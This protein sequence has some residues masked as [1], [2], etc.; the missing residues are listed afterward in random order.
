MSALAIAFAAA[1]PGSA[2]ALLVATKNVESLKD[3]L[4]LDVRPADAYAA[5][6][7]PGALNLDVSSLSE[8]RDNISGLLKPID[9]VRTSLGNA[10]VDP[11]KRIVVYSAMDKAS[12]ISAAAR[13]FWILEYIGYEKVAVLDGGFTK[14]LAEK[15]STE[16]GAST[17]KPVAVL[18]L[19]VREDRL[20]TME[21]VGL[22]IKDK[23]ATLVDARGPDYFSGE[24]KAD[25]VKKAGHLPGAVNLPV[26]TCVSETSDLK[27]WD[28]L[29]Q[30]AASSNVHKVEPVIT[31]CNTGRSA[32]AAYLVLRLLGYENVS[33]YD[34]SMAEWTDDDSRP[35]EK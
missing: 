26:E 33:M 23:K 14:W 27:S 4:L 13:M 35:V 22:A 20:A 8:T 7:I 18:E 15:R 24:K 2:S 17:A 28:E 21:N 34:G 25:V 6:H 9:Q 11:S 19:K 30:I 12:D 31:Y 5:A 29:Q 10:G 16:Q 3:S 1:A 32:S